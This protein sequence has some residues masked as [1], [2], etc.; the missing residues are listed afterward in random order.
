MR[1]DA[2]G[3]RELRDVILAL[4]TSD[5]D[6]RSAIRTFTRSEL[7]RPWLEAMN[8][9]ASTIVERRVLSATATVQVSDQNIRITS[10]A[11]GRTLSGGLSPKVDYAPVE[12]GAGRAKRTYTRKGHK[13]SRVT[14]NQFRPRNR[15]GY[16]FYPAASEM[17]PRLA[18]LW[19]QTVVKTYADIFDG[20]R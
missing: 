11:K 7:I 13:V 14:T 1:I 6:V 16:V 3:S 5:R 10:A 9:R 12:F 18:R 15:R 2:R 4:K 17:I 20:K 8:D 19:V